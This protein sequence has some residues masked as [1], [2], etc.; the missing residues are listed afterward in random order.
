MKTLFQ[1]LPEIVSTYPSVVGGMIYAPGIVN[2]PTPPALLELY[3]AEQKS[4]VARI[5]STPLSELPTLTAWRGAFRKFGVDPTQYRSASESL[6]RRLTKKADIPSINTLVDIGNLVSIRYALPVAMVDLRGVTGGLSVCFAKG[7]EIFTPLEAPEPETPDK[8]EVVFVD[9]KSVAAARRW[10]W[11]QSKE[12]AARKDTTDILVTVEAH[13]ADGRR[14]IEAALSDLNV[15]LDRFAPGTRA[16]TV[17]D[18]YSTA[19]IVA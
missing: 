15:M 6:L 8:G 16:S 7:D 9:E 2:G 13:H 4:V 5:G 3:M 11:R 17:L 12:S 19:F 18:A 10:C 14:D 1:Y